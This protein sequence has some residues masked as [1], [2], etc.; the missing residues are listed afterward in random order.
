VT[1][2]ASTRE[3]GAEAAVVDGSANYTALSSDLYPL[4]IQSESIRARDDHEREGASNEKQI[5]FG[6]HVNAITRTG[7]RQKYQS[8]V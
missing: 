4:I 3:E 8:H 7:S 1:V 6:G 5:K 2:R